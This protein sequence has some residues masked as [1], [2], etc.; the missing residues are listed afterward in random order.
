MTKSKL[1]AEMTPAEQAAHYL[2]FAVTRMGDDTIRTTY[3]LVSIAA[4]LVAQQEVSEGGTAHVERAV[5]DR[6]VASGA[7]QA[8]EFIDRQREA[9]RQSGDLVMSLQTKLDTAR[10]ILAQAASDQPEHEV[11]WLRAFLDGREFPAITPEE[12]EPERDWSRVKAHLFNP[13]GKWKYQVWLDYAGERGRGLPGEGPH[14]WHYDGAGMA[15]RALRRAT[16]NGTSGVTIS[17]LGSYWHL[18]VSD[19]PQG[20]PLWVHPV[21]HVDPHVMANQLREIR[22]FVDQWQSAAEDSST[23]DLRMGDILEVL[24]RAEQ[25]SEFT[26]N[27]GEMFP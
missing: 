2:N 25:G 20:V 24:N 10:A 13:R 9:L 8:A 17:D 21:N 5:Y 23:G 11:R 4:S 19:P 1:T 12:P 15:S 26:P 7:A 18:F 22:E 6:G 3:A 27:A 14:G 16:E